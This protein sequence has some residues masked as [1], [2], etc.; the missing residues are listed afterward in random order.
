MF[1]LAEQGLAPLTVISLL[2]V[3]TVFCIIDYVKIKGD[4]AMENKKRNTDKVVTNIL[5]TMSSS[6]AEDALL[7]KAH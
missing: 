1:W 4:D 5:F 6:L 7:T 2:I 3:L